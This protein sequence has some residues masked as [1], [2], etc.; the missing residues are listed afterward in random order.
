M[1]A[2]ELNEYYEVLESNPYQCLPDVPLSPV[3]I[4]LQT[5]YDEACEKIRKYRDS[6]TNL[7]VDKLELKQ[8]NDRLQIQVGALQQEIETMK[9]DFENKIESLRRKRSMLRKY[10]SSVTTNI[11]QEQLSCSRQTSF[12]DLETFAMDEEKVK[13]YTGFPSTEVFLICLKRLTDHMGKSEHGQQTKPWQCFLLTL[14]RL[15]HSLSLQDLAYRFGIDKSTACRI[16]NKWNT[17]MSEC[18]AVSDECLIVL[19]SK[20]QKSS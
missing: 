13:F 2:E 3:N 16:F 9:K 18:S 1:P 11:M 10:D 8:E 4:N 15:K 6:I 12:C 14:M 19:K 17:A 5:D 7:E 20:K